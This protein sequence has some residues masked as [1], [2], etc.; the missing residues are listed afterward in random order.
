MAASRNKSAEFILTLTEEE[1]NQLLNWLEERMHDKLIE[2]HR[3]K[4]TDFRDL[5]IHQQV[6]LEDLIRK[7]RG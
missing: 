1:R 3:T 4:T 7:L 6:V 2:E 5:L